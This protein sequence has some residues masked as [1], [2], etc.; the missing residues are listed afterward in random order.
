MHTNT[1]L[2]NT[3]KVLCVFHTG[4]TRKNGELASGGSLRDFLRQRVSMQQH[5]N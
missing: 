4:L 3:E 1:S 5:Q 2:Q